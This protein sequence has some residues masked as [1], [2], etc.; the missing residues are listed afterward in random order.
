MRA[1]EALQLRYD[2]DELGSAKPPPSPN[3]VHPAY[4][5]D[6]HSHSFVSGSSQEMY[7]LLSPGMPRPP[8][9]TAV[10]VVL[11]SDDQSPPSSY[12]LR[13][14]RGRKIM[15]LIYLVP[16]RQ[17]RCLSTRLSSTCRAP[18]RRA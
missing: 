10:H 7:G 13:G 14:P 16:P 5:I 4:L 8:I 9:K 11:D 3:N 2:T 17:S 1:T 12:V 18:L 15:K 6:A